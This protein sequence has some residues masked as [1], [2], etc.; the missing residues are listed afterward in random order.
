MQNIRRLLRNILCAGSLA[1]VNKAC[2]GFTASALVLTISACNSDSKHQ[3]LVTSNVTISG[4][5]NL[6][7]VSGA[8]PGDLEAYV[9][10]P[11]GTR[12]KAQE[13]TLDTRSGE[14]TLQLTPEQILPQL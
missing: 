5:I 6:R 14:F 2:A 7:S 3:Y 1:Q 11:D 9:V 4:L 13:F 8:E 10:L 12:Q